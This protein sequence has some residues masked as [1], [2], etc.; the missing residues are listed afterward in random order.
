ME[1]GRYGTPKNINDLAMALM[2]VPGNV[3][4]QDAPLVIDDYLNQK[5][6]TLMLEA[7]DD[8][9][10]LAWIEE[11]MHFFKTGE[12]YPGAGNKGGT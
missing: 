4:R 8:P 12:R 11:I 9:A 1:S 10:T 3:Y 5:F 7:G 6:A 2:R